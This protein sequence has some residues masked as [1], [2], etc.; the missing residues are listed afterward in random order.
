VNG[1]KGR[2]KDLYFDDQD[3]SVKYLV[4]SLGGRTANTDVLVDPAEVAGFDLPGKTL[5]IRLTVEQLSNCL[6]ASSVRPVC[7]Q[8]QWHPG[9]RGHASVFRPGSSNPYLRSA[10]VLLGYSLQ[11]QGRSVGELSGFVLDL[12]NWTIHSIIVEKQVSTKKL[13]FA[14]DPAFVERISFA[15]GQVRLKDANPTIIESMPAAQFN[16]MEIERSGKAEL[17]S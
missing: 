12:R 1:A 11:G 9:A 6:P 5:S 17:A 7:Q 8:Y 15:A 13:S 3:W 16:R 14:V 2:I 4:V 10:R